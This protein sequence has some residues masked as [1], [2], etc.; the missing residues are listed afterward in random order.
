[1]SV[2]REV[3]TTEVAV[4]ER[5]IEIDEDA[6]EDVFILDASERCDRQQRRRGE[7]LECRGFLGLTAR[8]RRLERGADI[9]RDAVVLRRR[10]RGTH[11][12]KRVPRDSRIRQRGDLRP[13]TNDDPS[14]RHRISLPCRSAVF[15]FKRSR[16]HRKSEGQHRDLCCDSDCDSHLTVTSHWRERVGRAIPIDALGE[17]LQ[18]RSS[19]S[20]LETSAEFDVSSNPAFHTSTLVTSSSRPTSLLRRM[21]FPW[22]RRRTSSCPKGDRDSRKRGTSWRSHRSS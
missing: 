15:F 8:D 6:G 10:N 11:E 2:V 14:D 20:A 9:S 16:R 21:R 3:V 13:Q 19:R 5:R 7:D 22:Y 17:R 4:T 12:S 18:I 1:M